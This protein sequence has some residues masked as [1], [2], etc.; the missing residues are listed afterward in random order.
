MK[1]MFWSADENVTRR[2]QE[3]NPVFPLITVVLTQDTGLTKSEFKATLQ[4]MTTTD[5]RNGLQ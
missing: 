1:V 5:N 3:R 2:F 4:N